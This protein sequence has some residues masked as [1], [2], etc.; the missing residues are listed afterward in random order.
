MHVMLFMMY[1]YIASYHHTK[2]SYVVKALCLYH[3]CWL[4]LGGAGWLCAR[5]EVWLEPWLL[6][7]GVDVRELPF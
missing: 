7:I 2:I 5:R 6:E 1:Q 3:A 4:A